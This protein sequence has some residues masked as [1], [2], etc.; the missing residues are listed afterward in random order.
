MDPFRYTGKVVGKTLYVNALKSVILYAWELGWAI[1]LKVQK[2]PKQRKSYWYDHADCDLSGGPYQSRFGDNWKDH[3]IKG[4]T[5][6]CII[7]I[8]DHLVSEGNLLFADNPFS[9]I[10][11]IYHDALTQCWE[12]AT[13]EHIREQEF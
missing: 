8:M 11:M 3:I 10:W 12:K 9:G 2:Y 13:K 5:E 7:V 1:R 4:F 6:V